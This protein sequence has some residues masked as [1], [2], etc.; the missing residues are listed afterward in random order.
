MPFGI[1]TLPPLALLAHIMNPIRKMRPPAASRPPPSSARACHFLGMHV[2]NRP[3]ESGRLI[4]H[5]QS[6]FEGV[7]LVKV[8]VVPLAAT[9]RRTA[10]IVGDH[11]ATC[12][13][14][15]PV[16]GAS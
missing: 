16:R 8:A 13:T 5:R 14:S 15:S 3:D 1:F 2:P 6:L 10:K 4:F 7:L 9:M 12:R 11:S